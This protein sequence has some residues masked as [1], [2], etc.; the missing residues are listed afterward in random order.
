MDFGEPARLELQNIT[1]G[2]DAQPILQDVSFQIPHGARVAVVGPNG[3]GK[4]TLFKALVGLLP[5]RAGSVCIHGRPMGNHLDCIAY[6]PQREDVDWRFPVTVSDVVMMGRYGRLGWVRRPTERIVSRRPQ[7]ERDGMADLADGPSAS[8]PAGSSSASSW[9]ARWRSSRTFCS[10]MSHSRAWTCRRKRRRWACWT[11]CA[12]EGV[13]VLVSTHDLNLAAK[14]FDQVVL[15]N[16]RLIACGA[17]DGL[18]AGEHPVEAFGGQVLYV[19]GAA[20]VDQCCP[21]D[22]KELTR[23]STMLDWL[24]APLTYGFM[25]RGLPP[26]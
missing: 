17:L 5:L 26:R 11:A 7:P 14:H 21:P 3:A 23:M 25:Q 8:C 1:V 24:L 13:T 12:R 9:R 18:H 4:S 2:Y 19:D 10:W 15:L 16:R 20:V 6:V 22:E